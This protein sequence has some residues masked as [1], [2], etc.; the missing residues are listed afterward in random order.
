[1]DALEAIFTRR[2]VRYYQTRAV[3]EEQLQILL[4]AA[5]NA[6]SAGNEQAWQFIVITDR[7]IMDA[8]AEFHPHAQM[9]TQAPMAVLICG[10]IRHQQHEGGW[11]LDCAA[12]TQNMLLAAHATG[13][14]AVWVGIHP[15]TERIERIRD[16]IGLP[17]YIVPV[18]LVPIGHPA[19]TPSPVR[20]YD[21]TRVRK[22]RW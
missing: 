6:P 11:V 20:R 2:S 21:S 19:D 17:S 9:L 14:G 4:E 18:S 22:N 3:S 1:M 7:G 15:N 16:L 8:I 5:M 12:A 13:L 10:D